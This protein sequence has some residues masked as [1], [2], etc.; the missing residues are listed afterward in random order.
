MTRGCATLGGNVH[1]TLVLV[2]AVQHE[3][4]P[5]QQWS[6][7]RFRADWSPPCRPIPS[8]NRRRF[9]RVRYTAWR[10]DVRNGRPFRSERN[11]VDEGGHLTAWGQP[12]LLV[13]EMRSA[14]RSQ[15]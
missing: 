11:E 14:V 7:L 1:H 5:R 3:G 12:E 2:C 10:L 15:R 8:S 9:N 13:G 4:A 6:P